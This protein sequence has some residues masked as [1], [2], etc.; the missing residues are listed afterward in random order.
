[1]IRPLLTPRKITGN[2]TI[3]LVSAARNSVRNIK[4]STDTISNAPGVTKEQKFGMNYV[5]FFG[6][7]KN[8]KILDKSLKTIRDSMV[9]TFGI[10]NAL[11]IAVKTGQGI[12][13]FIGKIFKFAG[14]ILNL[15]PF[16]GIIKTFL[17]SIAV[18]GLGGLFLK[19]KDQILG[20]FERSEIASKIFDAIKSKAKGFTSYI[21]NIIAEFLVSRGTSP[22][23][24][25]IRKASES[26]LSSAILESGKT[27]DSAIVA[28]DNEVEL[29]KKERED[30]KVNQKPDS[31]AP[32]E[33]KDFYRNTLKAFDDRIT[34]LQTGR[35]PVEEPFK[36]P[37]KIF[38]R[39]RNIPGTQYFDVIGKFAGD[40]TAQQG[41]YSQRDL[42]G[43]SGQERLNLIKS[44]LREFQ[45]REDISKAKLIY[46]REYERDDLLNLN[47]MDQA[48]D[49]LRYLDAV[50]D[51]FANNEK[52]DKQ[53]IK[54][55]DSVYPIM[56]KVKSKSLTRKIFDSAFNLTPVGRAVNS[57]TNLSV[58]PMGNNSTQPDLVRNDTGGLTSGPSM[59][60][61]SNVDQDNYVAL[62]NKSSLNVV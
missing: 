34:E 19:F 33:S 61:Y 26:R 32:D 43:L 2:A 11:K 56:P 23:F 37:F 20:F 51:P 62:I 58:L 7:K 39:Q 27:Q 3:G 30:F 52:I 40:V 5:G 46:G 55:L 16:S 28:R 18:G 41:I 4:R 12:F 21:K 49:I 10:A 35:V 44:T 54:Q 45:N 57:G 29:L 25:T 42:E 48:K 1:M 8:S 47:Q 14:S 38:G 9:S 13:G 6:S 24:Q 53:F 36:T 15:L 31:N 59:R 50:E 17:V 60:L 22:E